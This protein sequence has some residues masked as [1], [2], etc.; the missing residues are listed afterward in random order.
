MD[1]EYVTHTHMNI[2]QLLEN[3]ILLFSTWV[4]LECNEMSD[5]ERQLP[6]FA[7]I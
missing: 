7:Y 6:S 2:I 5:T 4:D 3:E 1:N